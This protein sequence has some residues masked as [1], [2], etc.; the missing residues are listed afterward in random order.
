VTAYRDR[1]PVASATTD[2]IGGFRL[3]L[4]AGRYVVVARNTGA[5]ATT[6]QRS[7]VVTAHEVSTIV[8][9]VDSGIR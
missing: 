6:A 5:L 2:R 7:V 9:V 8:L 3:S 1:H 4:A